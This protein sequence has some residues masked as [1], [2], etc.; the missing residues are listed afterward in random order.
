MSRIQTWNDFSEHSMERI[1]K[2]QEQ[3]VSFGE[4][5]R[6]ENEE[7]SCSGRSYLSQRKDRAETVS[8]VA[9]RAWPCRVVWTVLWP[10]SLTS[11]SPDPYGAAENVRVG[12]ALSDPSGKVGGPVCS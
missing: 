11:Q 8:G 2:G 10:Q 9:A 4:G 1:W 6:V 12:L 5:S 3:E 7:P